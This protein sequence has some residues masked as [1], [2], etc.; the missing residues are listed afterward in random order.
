[1]NSHPART[2]IYS[3]INPEV[4]R[5][6]TI[7]TTSLIIILLSCS[8][9][10][11]AGQCTNI[12]AYGTAAAPT[13]ATPITISSCVYQEEYNTV[14]G[15]AAATSYTSTNSAGGCITVHQGTPGGPV[16]GFG[17][18][19]L[20]WTS[21][22][23][24]TYYIHYTTN[25]VTC[26]TSTGCTTSTIA[27]NS[28]GGG[29]SNPCTSPVNIA[30]C[31]TFVTAN[32]NGTGAGWSITN[33]GFTTPGDEVIYTFTPTVT[34]IYSLNITAQ[35][36]GYIDYFWANASGG[37]SA[38]ATWNCIQDIFSA[39]TYGAMSWTA[40]NTYYILLDPEGTGTY[41][42][43][44][45]IDCPS[46][47]PCSTITSIIGCGTS[48]MAS[49]TGTG[50]PWNFTSCMGGTT[51]GTE[52]IWSFTPTT[53]GVHT[54]NVTG[55]TGG[56]IDLYWMNSATGCSGT[57]ANWNCIDE[58]S[59]TGSFGSMNW[60]A[61]VTYYILLDPEI[62][63][64]STLTFD[65]DCPQ[66]PTPAVAGDCNVAIPVCT[67]LGFQI[68]P[69]GYGLVDELCTYC[70]SNPGTNPADPANWGCLL[71]GELNSTWFTVNVAAG[72]TLE[73]SFGAPGTVGN[74]YDWI[75]WPYNPTACTAISSNTLAP[76][77]C[78]WNSPCEDRKSVV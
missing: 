76:T 51:I 32:M 68:D 20:S 62:T 21:T 74:C 8:G 61:G 37:C 60:T 13:T 1:M 57:E 35:S 28:C 29:G 2:N 65:I 39:G 78:N 16:V 69:S 10:E 17:S 41:S 31:G 70:T 55:I 67:N 6:Q 48:Q 24:G 30:S 40:G 11:A 47:G 45:S 7:F 18:S 46:S 58:V 54:I 34:G 3:L 63:A 49:M 64:T 43:T 22:V 23:A 38:G 71:S 5:V 72:G 9:F 19:P 25:C 53:T 26:A 15:V 36:G 56:P 73:F 77:T 4:M 66:P 27:C 50:V 59:T 44:F 75:M 42:S 52:S 12:F 33:C 14:T